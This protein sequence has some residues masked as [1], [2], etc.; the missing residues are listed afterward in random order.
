M[1]DDTRH[2][3]IFFIC[4]IMAIILNLNEASKRKFNLYQNSFICNHDIVCEMGIIP[5]NEVWRFYFYP[6]QAFLN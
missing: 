6:T 5:K 2:S 4:Q 3:I 1:A